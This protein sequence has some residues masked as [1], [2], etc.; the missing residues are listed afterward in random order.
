MGLSKIYE[1]GKDG[2]QEI[3]DNSYSYADVLKKMGMS[4]HGSNYKTLNKAIE[5]FQ[6]DVT[7]I[8]ANRK[9]FFTESFFQYRKEI[10]LEEIIGGNYQKEYKGDRLRDR[11][12]KGGYKQWV[13]EKCGLDSWLGGKIPL[14]LHHK[15]GN[16][17]NNKLDNLQLLC[18]NCHSL[19]DTYAGK[20]VKYKKIDHTKR[21]A[22][23]GL[24]DDGQRLYDGYGDYKILC[25]VCKINF[26]S[27]TA[28]MCSSCFKSENKKPKISKEELYK[29]IDSTKSYTEVAKILN[30]D[31]KTI[32]RWHQYYAEEDI[33][34]GKQIIISDKAPSREILKNEIRNNSFTDIGR[35]YGDVNGNSVKK[36]CQ[37]YGLPHLKSVIKK[38]PDEEW[39]KI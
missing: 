2:L 27:K 36:W 25:P 23:K 33:S 26:M 9:Q 7:K 34:N 35:R 31:R 24:S 18:P 6:I 21:V 11:L 17:I 10:P 20:N 38:I 15:D 8:S 1:Y 16:H 4:A 3:F 22:K 19:T 30:K 5:E 12:I 14:H 37:K 39:D 13:C 29:L 28:K 32:K